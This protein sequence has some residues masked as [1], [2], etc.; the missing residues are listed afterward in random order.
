MSDPYPHLARGLAEHAQGAYFEAHEHFEDAWR[1][2]TG[3]SRELLQALVQISAAAVKGTKGNLRGTGKLLDKAA[4]RLGGIEA[5]SHLGLDLVDLRHQIGAS[6]AAQAEGTHR[7][8]PLP[9]RTSPAGVLYLHGFASSPGS[10]KARA[11]A[12]ALEADG[13]EVRVPDLNEGGFE[14][15]TVSRILDHAERLLFDRTLVIGSSLGGY[16]A[17]LLQ[18]RDP[19]VVGLVLMAP[20]FDFA[21]RLRDRHG[22]EA[23]ER[24]RREG[25]FDVEHYGYGDTRPIGYGLL[26]DARGH[27]GRPHPTV[28]TY[29]LQGEHDDVVPA[30][31]VRAVVAEAGPHVR[32]DVVDDDHGLGRSA[33]CALAAARRLAVEV[34]LQ[35]SR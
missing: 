15:L 13:L 21:D 8:V 26:E 31:M 17:T 34:G 5:K 27:P 29:V 24:W 18:R 33:D 2:A 32:L 30:D 12:P 16:S 7:P 11:I 23:L 3:D 28:P 14:S 22:P 9:P 19:R 6:L 25:A 10:A 35:P 1:D 4:A 20:A